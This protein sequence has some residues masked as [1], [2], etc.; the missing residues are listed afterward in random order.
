MSLSFIRIDNNKQNDKQRKGEKLGKI[1]K[2]IKLKQDKWLKHTQSFNL[3]D[4]LNG[5]IYKS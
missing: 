2:S 1:Q 5:K 4:Y 3:Y